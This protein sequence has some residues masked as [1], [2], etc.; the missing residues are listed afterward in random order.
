MRE[1]LHLNAI[2]ATEIELLDPGFKVAW[3]V[4]ELPS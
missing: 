1:A 3:K 4:G 2:R